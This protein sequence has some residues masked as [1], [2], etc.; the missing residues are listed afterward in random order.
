MH[1]SH[2]QLTVLSS[3][4]CTIFTSA[5]PTVQFQLGKYDVLEGNTIQVCAVL[6]LPAGTNAL[7]NDIDIMFSGIPGPIAG[8]LC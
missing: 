3:F 4:I 6:T 7:G 8:L 5:T 1:L 2:N